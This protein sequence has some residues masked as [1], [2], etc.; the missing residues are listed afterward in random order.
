MKTFKTTH[1][2]FGIGLLTISAF[3]FS[4]FSNNK[5]N[6]A[7]YRTTYRTIPRGCVFRTLMGEESSDSNF[8][9]KTPEKVAASIEKGLTWIVS[10]Q[11]P[12]GGWGA[13]S[14]RRQDVMDP[15]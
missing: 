11:H 8:V 4:S 14:H 2:A 9:F 7:T 5:K 12:S 1:I 6:K 3:V 15:H 13:G 10:A